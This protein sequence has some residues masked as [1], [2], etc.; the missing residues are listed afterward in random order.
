MKFNSKTVTGDLV[1]S[2]A[3]TVWP[4][5]RT[6]AVSVGPIHYTMTIFIGFYWT[7]Y[8]CSGT[9]VL[10]TILM[11]WL[12]NYPLFLIRYLLWSN[13]LIAISFIGVFSSLELQK[14]CP[15]L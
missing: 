4:S 15:P 8:T 2:S 5:T 11:L 13:H 9:H 12:L 10:L 6:S 7:Q 1:S 14:N 3:D